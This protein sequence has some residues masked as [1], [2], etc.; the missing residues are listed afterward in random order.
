VYKFVVRDS[1]KGLRAGA[2]MVGSQHGGFLRRVVSVE[3]GGG[4]TLVVATTDATL[5]EAVDTGSFAISVPL[6]P[7][8]SETFSADG[9]LRMG[10]ARFTYLDPGI[11]PAGAR[12]PINN[13]KLYE[14][15]V[16]RGGACSN[17]SLTLTTGYIDLSGS[18][19]VNV[20]VGTKV[21]GHVLMKGSTGISADVALVASDRLAFSGEKVIASYTMAFVGVVS[22]YVSV[23]LVAQFSTE[24]HGSAQI[25]TGF[26]GKA[27]YEFGGRYDG[28]WQSV[29]SFTPEFNRH[30]LDFTLS[31][32]AVT[33]VSIVPRVKA[34]VWG[35]STG[36][37]SPEPYLEYSRQVDG[38]RSESTSR[39]RAG[40]D[41]EASVNLKFAT[42]N[43]AEYRRSFT[44]PSITLFE[45]TESLGAGSLRLQVASGNGQQGTAGTRLANPITVK[46]LDGNGGA[47][48]GIPVDFSVT[49]GGGS[50]STS[51]A[52]SNA[53]GLAAAEW[54]LGPSPGP[55]G[56]RAAISG[57]TAQAVTFTATGAA[58]TNP[59]PLLT[60]GGVS[61]LTS[62]AAT[63]HGSVQPKGH[64]AA[65]YFHWGPNS[66][67]ANI[68]PAHQISGSQ[69]LAPDSVRITGLQPGTTYRY[70]LDGSTSQGSSQ[71][72]VLFFTTPTGGE[73]ICTGAQAVLRLSSE[74]YP[75]NVEVPGGT[76]FNK[77]WTLRNAGDCY[78]NSSF[79]LRYVSSSAGR[80]STAQGII[81]ISGTV[82]PDGTVTFTVPMVAPAVAGV[83]REDWRVADAS[84]TTVRVGNSHSVWALIKSVAAGPSPMIS[85]IS[86]TSPTAGPANQQIHVSGSGFQP[87][88]TVTVNYPGGSS[89]LSGNQILNVTTTGFDILA[90]LGT[91]GSYSIRVNNPGGA[92][93][94]TF[95]FQVQTPPL[96]PPEITS[97]SP[98]SPTASQANQQVRVNGSGFQTGLTVTVNYPGGSSTLSGNQI[99]N[100]TALGFDMVA[101]LGTAGSYSIRVNNP[102]G[103]QSNTFGFLVQTPPAPQITSITPASPTASGSNQQ[104][105]V[106]GSDFQA[107]LT[108][109][110]NY[111]G[112]SS[113]LSGNQILNVTATGFD[114]L[115]LLG[116]AG[117]YS[118]RVNNP[119]G[120]QSNTFSFQVQA[121]PVAA[122]QVSSISPASPTASPSNQQIRVS[123]TGFQ[124]GLTVT[125]NYPGGSSTLSGNQIL[126]VTAMGFDI[127][128]VL[129]T[130]GTY[131]IRV[132]NPGG[133]QSNT[134]GFLVQA[135]P[136]PQISSIAPA[137]PT[138]SPSNQQIRVNGS[139]FQ[140]GLTVTVNYPGGTSTL[141]GNQIL[142]VTP[143][144][145]DVLAVLSTA[146]SYSFRVNN[147]GGAQSNV[148]AF[149][150]QPP[151]APQ[152]SS[153][154]P[155]SPTAGPSNQQ[156]RINGSG[157]ASGLTVTV[158]YPGGSSTLSGNQ[159]L[160]VSP[161]G[162]DVLALL[163]TAGSYSFRVN[164][165]GGVQS[166]T[167]GFQVQAP[168]A[169]QINSITPA[170]P[171]A[172]PSNQ[173]IRING[174]GFVSGLTATVTYP[175]GSSTLSG[176]QIL[177]VTPTGFD[178]LALLG[179]AGSYSFRAN[180]PGGVHSNTFGF[181]VQVPTPQ[182]S[183]ISPA[184][185]TAGPSNQQI[186]INGS[187]FV[188]GLTVTVTFPGGSST[189]SGNQILN[190]TPTGFDVLALLGTGGS[191]SFRVNNPGGVQSNTF[192]FQVQAPPAPQISS[193]SPSSPTAKSSNQQVRI[194][195]SGFVAG[196]TVTVQ[197]PGGSSTLSGNQILNVTGSGFDV[198][199]LLG[200]PGSYSFRVNNPGG[201]QSNTFSFQV[202][203]PP[204]PQISSISPSSPTAGPSN[205]QVRINGS[206]FVAGLTVTVQ[207]SG[208]SS[209]LSGN[210][211]LNVTGSGFD[212]LALLGI[213]GNYSFRVNNPGGSQSN[214]FSFQVQ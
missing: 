161:T 184:S 188:S 3:R 113:T 13:V 203:P 115:A 140:S 210:Q 98:A 185:P 175:G 103:G 6:E 186:R 86:P 124:P 28:G 130:P 19:D 153:I 177:N 128:A 5:T 146:G 83:Y 126:N 159:I 202:Q 1:I 198:L 196:L 14:N 155:A 109:T 142:N 70:R 21:R 123:G 10:T 200:V 182:I 89:T 167:F 165:P 190:V 137:S 66:A 17:L 44:G 206:G 197:Y 18:F 99:L 101:L 71:G 111:P 88:L 118:I 176:N 40:V 144:G 84:G 27:T 29:S 8:A 59:G 110:V 23:D 78:L 15:S 72:D 166:N 117:S 12:W 211:I 7:S 152:I 79:A 204:A 105:R 162:F 37:F 160:N 192:S 158:T 127:L 154:S 145:F 209:T 194:N 67:L 52:V 116:T 97:I 81:P 107:G 179:T 181:Q 63:L 43:I 207:Y 121:P 2:V 60:T 34:T 32:G 163:G 95:G 191:Y 49:G 180:N 76:A 122:P 100:V 173:Q 131:S 114:I 75:D 199:A 80:L 147:P 53:A 108:V 149:Q 62:T 178:V 168:P 169:P 104:I 212:V 148:F 90:L 77:S 213:P 92:Q 119:G 65:V 93:S 183:S 193:I 47:V 50:L 135:P 61:N 138:A 201:A 195:G 174:S 120:A 31:G 69:T 74:T 82:P 39:L 42:I 141:S 96:T 55:N 9:Q 24:V 51:R 208:G 73:T 171:T 189:L 94:N 170:S 133:A 26:D 11:A 56:A 33:R 102:G 164:N 68:T 205:Q 58:S 25:T 150:V 139:G 187:G 57:L 91:A 45:R 112:G 172:G 136:A 151:P 41:A 35:V 16:C 30:A 132:N 143:T 48:G 36:V 156:I 106:N 64:D 4:D 54:T 157:F 46:V 134:F 125:V 214:T 85:A 22:G 38:A 129:G 87:G 20:D